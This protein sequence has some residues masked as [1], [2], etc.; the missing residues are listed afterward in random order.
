M[1]WASDRSENEPWPIKG[2]TPMVGYASYTWSCVWCETTVIDDVSAEYATAMDEANRHPLECPK[3][4]KGF[5]RVMGQHHI[6]NRD[7][8]H[9]GLSDNDI[10]EM[11]R[12]LLDE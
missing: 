2:P 12:K 11:L 10:L 1:T 6:G 9:S 4:P 3:K 8:E 7:R 5:H